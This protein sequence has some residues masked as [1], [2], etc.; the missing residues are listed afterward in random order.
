[1]RAVAAP[2]LAV[3]LSMARALPVTARD[4]LAQVEFASGAGVLRDVIVL[5]SDTGAPLLDKLSL[6]D[7]SAVMTGPDRTRLNA[8]LAVAQRRIMPPAA[9]LALEPPSVHT[10]DRDRTD[11]VESDQGY[12]IHRLSSQSLL[13]RP[14][15]AR[16]ATDT[17]PPTG[18]G[19]P[20][21][22]RGT[23]T[24]RSATQRPAILRLET[25]PEWAD[26]DGQSAAQGSAH[27]GVR[28][29]RSGAICGRPAWRRRPASIG[30]PA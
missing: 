6:Y 5:A 19:S 2:L 23:N 24:R 21:A 16:R 20:A 3:Y 10:Y 7:A 18:G 27:K 8:M 26:G 13:Q 17:R 30:S 22:A 4:I 9:A 12:R 15:R 28:T 29:P 11:G 1:M 25:P 14:S